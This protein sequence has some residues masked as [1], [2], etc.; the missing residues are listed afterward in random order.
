MLK[1]LFN[2]DKELKER[3]PNL[4]EQKFVSGLDFL[5][6]KVCNM[7]KPAVVIK[8]LLDAGKT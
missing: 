8:D 5:P 6:S 2:L 1:T 3:V 4:L 7:F